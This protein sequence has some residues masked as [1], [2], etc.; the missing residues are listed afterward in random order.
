[1][2]LLVVKATENT[3]YRRAT[4]SRTPRTLSRY[5]LGCF[6]VWALT[7]TVEGGSNMRKVLTFLSASLC[8]AW[9]APA[10]AQ[11]APDKFPDVPEDHWAYKAIDS[12]R[13]KGI[14]IGYPDGQYRGKRTMSRYEFAVAIDRA[15]KSLPAGP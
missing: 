5:S 3:S 13:A 8:L 4:S 7:P 1:M 6:H 2:W 14:L 10:R 15:L 9:V 11:Q 12:L